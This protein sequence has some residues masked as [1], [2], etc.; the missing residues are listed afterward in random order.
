METARNP[1]F[2]ADPDRTKVDHKPIP[3]EKV[4]AL[5]EGLYATPPELG[6]RAQF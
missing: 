3:G 4:Q 5:F 1:A 2:V 6:K